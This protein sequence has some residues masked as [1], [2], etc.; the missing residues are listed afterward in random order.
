M[1][2]KIERCLF[3][4][5]RMV[6]RMIVN[7]SHCF[8]LMIEKYLSLMKEE[9]IIVSLKLMRLSMSCSILSY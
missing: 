9:K 6:V 7:L 5:L 2:R 8:D 3:G 1:E 4:L